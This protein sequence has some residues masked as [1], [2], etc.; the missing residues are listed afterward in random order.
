MPSTARRDFAVGLFVLAGLAAIG[1]LSIRLGGLGQQTEGGLVLVAP[2]DDVGGLKVRAPVEIAGV[3]VGRVV[4][5]RLG[6]D[7]R[8]DV[9]LNVDSRLKLPV[10][11]TAAIRTAGLLG[12]QFVS[13]E[14]GA[15]DQDLH[16][17]DVISY[18]NSALSLDKLVGALVHGGGD[19]G[20]GK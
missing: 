7:M 2:F 18:T 11:T 3:A 6:K 8:A 13:L 12:D 1:Y 15:E 20:G 10:D 4:Q 17:G 9:T 16:S 19:L 5:I 14:P